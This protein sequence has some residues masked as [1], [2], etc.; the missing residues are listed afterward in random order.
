MP[1]PRLY[2]NIP[3][4]H[5]IVWNRCKNPQMGLVYEHG[6]HIQHQE[7]SLRYLTE[8]KQWMHR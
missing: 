6:I 3:I 4:F 8:I 7:V 2:T 1:K 5:Q